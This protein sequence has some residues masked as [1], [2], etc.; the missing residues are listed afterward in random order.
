MLEGDGDDLMETS[1][2]NSDRVNDRDDF[3]LN[4]IFN[5]GITEA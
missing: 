5:A 1:D 4:S 3:R 2:G